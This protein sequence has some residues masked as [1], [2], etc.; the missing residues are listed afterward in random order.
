M[1]IQL[2]N[3]DKTPIYKQIYEAIR[4]QIIDGSLKANEQLPS[5]RLLAKDL[6][7]SVITTKR[8]YEDLE[9]DEFIY[10]VSGKGT[11]VTDQNLDIL[12]ANYV[13]EIE[14]L[15]EKIISLAYHASIDEKDLKEI[16]RK[17]KDKR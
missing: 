9:K 13:E 1:Y 5:I 14:A 3:K 8:A 11:Y 4:N 6:G 7:V 17:I 12:L 2:D 16:Y 15:M 10:T